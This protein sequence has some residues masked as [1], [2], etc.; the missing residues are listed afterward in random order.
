MAENDQKLLTVPELTAQVTT[1]FQETQVSA[2][3]SEKDLAALHAKTAEF[4]NKI[5]QNLEATKVTTT[6]ETTKLRDDVVTWSDGYIQKVEGMVKSGDFKY[7]RGFAHDGEARQESC[8]S[9][10]AG[11]RRQ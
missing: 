10:E 8:L 3:K 1:L 2:V 7:E 9:V 11:R 6:A 4:A 5:I